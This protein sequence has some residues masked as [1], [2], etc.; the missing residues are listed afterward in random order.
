MSVELGDKTNTQTPTDVLYLHLLI[1][2]LHDYYYQLLAKQLPNNV[3]NSTQQSLSPIQ[4]SVTVRTIIFHWQLQ[5]CSQNLTFFTALHS[6][7]HIITIHRVIYATAKSLATVLQ[8]QLT[9]TWILYRVAQKKGDHH[10]VCPHNLHKL[11]L[12]NGFILAE[13]KCR[14]SDIELIFFTSDRSDWVSSL[15]VSQMTG[16]VYCS[17][18]W[19]YETFQLMF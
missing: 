14:I 5:I 15:T 2:K 16:F 3:I 6:I 19:T 7:N 10:A 12:N 11:L 18:G 1:S 4:F 17:E 13:R 8:L 9:A